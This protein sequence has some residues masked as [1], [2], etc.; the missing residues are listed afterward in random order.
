[1][2][3]LSEV[4]WGPQTW[5]QG[6]LR[7][8]ARGPFCLL[9]AVQEMLGNIDAPEVAEQAE[10][11]QDDLHRAI[12]LVDPEFFGSVSAW[13]DREHRTWEDIAAVVDTF[14]RIRALHAR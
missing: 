2:K 1:M 12:Q 5:C 14:D 10:G 8:S 3:K 13:N 6:K 7:K 9:G 4:L 11:V